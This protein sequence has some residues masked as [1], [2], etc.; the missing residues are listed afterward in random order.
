[1][2]RNGT[3]AFI[4]KVKGLKIDNLMER[5]IENMVMVGSST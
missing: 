3:Y 5:Y 2:V 4:G 1:M